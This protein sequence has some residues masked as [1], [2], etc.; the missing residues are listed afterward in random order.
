[1]LA[2]GSVNETVT[3]TASGEVL[4]KTE[5]ATVGGAFE[6]QRIEKLPIFNRGAVTGT[7]LALQPAVSLSGESAGSRGDQNT[8]TLDGLDVSDQVG[9]RGS[10]GTVVPSRRNRSRSFVRRYQTRPRRS[11]ARAVHR[12]R[13]LPSAVAMS[14]MGRCIGIT[15]TTT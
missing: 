7:L 1:M 10:A 15:R 11:D 5:D 13:C 12:S 3:I 14:F 6:Q 2:T 4:L 8:F 9:F